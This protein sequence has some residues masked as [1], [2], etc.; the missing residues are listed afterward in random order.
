MTILRG[1]AHALIYVALTL[2]GLGW[3]YAPNSEVIA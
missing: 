2:F 1:F 3:L